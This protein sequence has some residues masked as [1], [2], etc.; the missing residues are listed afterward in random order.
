MLK[1]GPLLY[2]LQ[3]QKA[4]TGISLNIAVHLVNRIPLKYVASF[5]GITLETVSRVRK[6][7]SIADQ[8][9]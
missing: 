7:I 1:E 5:L 3:M 2:V 4:N 6:K 9:G 8:S